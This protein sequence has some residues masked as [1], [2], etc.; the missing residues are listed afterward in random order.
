MTTNDAQPDDL[1]GGEPAE[2]E[3]REGSVLGGRK[4]D[5]GLIGATGRDVGGN[6]GTGRLGAA[7]DAGVDEATGG[8]A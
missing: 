8:T 3:A 4:G 7:R 1:H 2:E 5:D 6:A